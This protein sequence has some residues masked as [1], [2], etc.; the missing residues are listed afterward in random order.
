MGKEEMAKGG[1]VRPS[2]LLSASSSSSSAAEREI[3]QAIK[4]QQ[5]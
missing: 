4:L 3:T 1:E 2:Y 5:R